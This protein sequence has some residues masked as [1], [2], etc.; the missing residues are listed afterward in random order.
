[1]SNPDPYNPD[2][3]LSADQVP[4]GEEAPFLISSDIEETRQER[5]KKLYRVYVA[6]PFSIIKSDWRAVFGLTVLSIYV[7]LAVYSV[8]FVE[9]TTVGDGAVFV[10]PFQTME[11]PFGTDIVGRDLFAMTLHSIIPILQMI[12]AGGL[13]VVIVGTFFGVTAGYT[14]GSIDTTLST[15]T[16]TFINLP[17]LPLVIVLAVIFEPTNPYLVGIL[18]SVAAWAGLARALRSQ[19]LTLRAESFTEASRAMGIPKYSIMIKDIL[20][21]LAPYLVIN[22]MNAARRVIFAAV[23]L[24]FLG[25]FPVEDLNWGVVLNQA[26]QNGAHYRPAAAHWLLVPMIAIIFIS[27]ALVLLGQSLDRVFNPRVR[28]RHAERAEG[29]PGDEERQVDKS[30]ELMGQI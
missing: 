12:T 19:V 26:Y 17:G 10:Q 16:D 8:F 29:D 3:G 20:P 14:G 22:L 27:V 4:T 21:H 13:F 15:I 25:V 28:A 11:H 6:T 30:S 7:V 9:P 18:L 24:Y 23:G 1:M 2:G 5:W